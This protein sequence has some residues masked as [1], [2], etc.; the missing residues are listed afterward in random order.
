MNTNILLKT[1]RRFIYSLITTVVIT[2]ILSLGF[3]TNFYRFFYDGTTEMFSFFQELQFLNKSLFNASLILIIITLFL[4]S[5]ELNKK[6]AGKFGLTY[7]I[8]TTLYIITTSR[9]L[10]SAIPYYRDK[11]LEFDFNLIQDYNPSTFVFTLSTFLLICIS[12]LSIAL[13]LVVIINYAKGRKSRVIGGS[14]ERI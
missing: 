14:N 1:Q 7:V 3:M 11:Y 2:F 6:K 10:L 5:F 8:V 12:L 9:T 4:L 13:L